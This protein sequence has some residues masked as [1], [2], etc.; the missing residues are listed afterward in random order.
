VSRYLPVFPLASPILPTQIL[1]MHIFEDRYRVLM[2]TLTEF[3]S[4]SEMGVVL[5]ERGSEVGG[6][7]V[8][9]RT[10]TVTHLIE[11]E[12]LPDGR[13][14]AIFTGSHP[15]TVERWLDDDPYPQAVVTERADEDWNPADQGRLLAATEAVNQALL[16]A[17]RLGEPL[18]APAIGLSERP[19]LAAWELC[20]R[21]PLGPIDRQKLLEC[22]D[23]SQ[24]LDLLIEL[25]A[26]ATALLAFR[27]QGK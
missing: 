23:R 7:D 17:A 6:G 10:G 12:R 3:G 1:P 13:W 26:D 5:I 4:A 20:A 18:G 2:E 15:F 25:V 24:R 8:R 16:L 21:A 19:V 14:V 9:V 11:S 27:L 22:P